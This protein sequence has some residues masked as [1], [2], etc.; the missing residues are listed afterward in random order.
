LKSNISAFGKNLAKS[1]GFL[2]RE[3]K[4]VVFGEFPSQSG[5]FMPLTR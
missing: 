1:D 4:V 3:R 2:S 5:G